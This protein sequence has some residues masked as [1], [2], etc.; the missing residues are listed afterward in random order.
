MA[1][2]PSQHGCHICDRAVLLPIIREFLLG[3]SVIQVCW[4]KGVVQAVI[5][6]VATQA[7]TEV[8]VISVE[9]NVALCGA[10][11]PGKAERVVGVDQHNPDDSRMLLAARGTLESPVGRPTRYSLLARGCR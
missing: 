8:N 6:G 11:H 4:D 10:S 5:F 2:L 9:V 7:G 3:F 1:A